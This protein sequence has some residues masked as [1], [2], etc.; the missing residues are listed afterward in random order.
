MAA[1]SWVRRWCSLAGLAALLVGWLLLGFGQARAQTPVVFWLP[2]KGVVN[3]AM[4]G[5]LDRGITEAEEAGAAA[6]VVELDTPGGALDATRDIM[7]RFNAA[8]VPVVVYVAPSGARAGSAGVFMT[9]AGHL[10]AMAPTT[11][12][13]AAHPV[14]SD[15]SDVD[16]A[17]GTLGT[18]IENDAVAMIRAQALRHHHNADWAEEAVRKSVSITSQEALERGVVDL[19]ATDRADL[20]RQLDGRTVSLA[21]GDVTLATAGARIEPIDRNLAEQFLDLLGNP[22]LALL[23]MVVGFNAV[24]Y[25]LANPNLILPGV[26]GAMALLM[27]LYGVGTLSPNWAGLLFIVLAFILFI[28]EVKVQSNG[29]LAVGAIASMIIGSL[30][31]TA[32]SPPW[33]RISPITIA[34]CVLWTSGVFLGLIAAAWRAQRQP[35][36]VGAETLVGQVGVARSPLEPEGM[37]FLNGAYWE[38]ATVEGAVS[39]G[40]RVQVTGRDG[41]KLYV[42]KVA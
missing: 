11:N 9:M 14:N 24:L 25:E 6:V 42:R 40:D 36:Y 20:L 5:Y 31:L 18:K 34:I 21:G 27:G 19:I 39:A 23:L 13:G 37:V 8:R 10:A 41:L 3:Q 1:R 22:N 26:V 16:K 7:Q 29:V 12:I 4:T 2:T 32:N 33:A 30:V 17:G 15:G 38:A 28:L 35:V